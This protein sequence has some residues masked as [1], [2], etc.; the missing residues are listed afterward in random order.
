MWHCRYQRAASAADHQSVA[1]TA[2]KGPLIGAGEVGVMAPDG[3]SC[4]Q[5]MLRGLL[6]CATSGLCIACQGG[7][8]VGGGVHFC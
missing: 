5:D 4:E 6:A 7:V 1:L 8:C 2:A 3:A